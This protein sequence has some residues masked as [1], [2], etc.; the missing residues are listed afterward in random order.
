MLPDDWPDPLLAFL[1][2]TYGAATGVD[3]LKG[4]SGAGVWRLEFGGQKVIVKYSDRGRESYFYRHVAPHL[5]LR[6]VP[7]PDVY[8]Q[9]Q[10]EQ[11]YWLVL[12]HLP[13]PLPGERWQADSAVFAVL[14][15]LH[16][17]A[18]PS[19]LDLSDMYQPQWTD[20]ITDAALS[21]LSDADRMHLAPI[22][23]EIQQASQILFA[24]SCPVSADPNPA[25]WGVRDNGTVVLFDWDRFTFAT[26]A[27]DLAITLPGLPD[28][29][30][31]ARAADVYNEFAATPVTAHDLAIA[32]I[33]SVTE[34]LSLVA[35]W[36]SL[37]NDHLTWLVQSYPQWVE[38]LAAMIEGSQHGG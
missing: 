32:K 21:C 30:A 27:L 4:L 23:H 1:H 6:N 9:W 35:T 12:E 17:S 37:S 8:W 36:L 7:M 19:D 22:L 10:D 24:P 20:A 33:W 2:T 11:G 26:P 5:R 13:Q 3:V 31:F 25:N 15:A 34:F 29:P 38:G 18:L 28:L 16:S 14:H